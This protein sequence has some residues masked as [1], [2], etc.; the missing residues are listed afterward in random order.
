MWRESIKQNDYIDAIMESKT[1]PTTQ[2]V[3]IFSAWQPAKI[4]LCDQSDNLLVSF[5]RCPG[6]M[7]KK[8]ARSSL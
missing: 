3:K 1:P 6:K 8:V 4:I 5:L 7:D 2:G